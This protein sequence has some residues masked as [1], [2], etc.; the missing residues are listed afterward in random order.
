[1]RP[2]GSSVTEHH[3]DRHGCR[4]GHDADGGTGIVAGLAARTRDLVAPL[5][6]DSLRRLWY[7]RTV[8]EAGSWAARIAMS[9]A[10]FAQ[11]RNPLAATAVTAVALL[12]HVGIGQVLGTLADRFPHRSVMVTADVVRGVVYLTLALV[13]PT[14]GWML[15][16]AFLAGLADPPFSAA[17]SAALPLLAGDRYLAAQRLFT[18]TRQAMTLLGFA[19]GGLMVAGW[20]ASAALAV[21]GASFLVSVCF[22]AGVRGTRSRAAG[23]RGPLLRPAVR[24]LTSDRLVVVSVCVV[25][26][27]T[28]LGTT[29]ES[30]MAPLAAHLGLG[31][32][33]AGLLATVPPAASVVAA[34]LLPS[35][36]QDGRLVRMVCRS[37]LLLAAVYVAVF[38]LDTPMPVALVGLAVAGALDVMTVPAGVVVGQRVPQESR[39]TAFSFLEGTLMLS[40]VVTA[41]V[42]GTVA[43][44]TSVALAATLLGLP[45]LVAAGIGLAVVRAGSDA[46]AV[47]AP[48]GSSV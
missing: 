8:S 4:A 28:V 3:P 21:N 31:S 48:A 13:H 41:L 33:G 38:A 18:S 19:V 34:V 46:A 5:A 14:A 11:T 27:G 45:A 39:G 32:T 2:P 7:A 17:Y 20:G 22:L 40:N 47:P 26:A 25:T 37:V 9:L 43:A 24:A 36:G 23:E 10:V 44:A 1:M 15:A 6:D 30:L 35:S 12:P 29:V 42:A 16:G